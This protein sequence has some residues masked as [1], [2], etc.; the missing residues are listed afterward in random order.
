MPF[1]YGQSLNDIQNITDNDIVIVDRTGVSNNVHSPLSFGKREFFNALNEAG[2]GYSV[3]E[4]LGNISNELII[5]LGSS[6]DSL[7]NNL[8]REN[9]DILKASAESVFYKRVN[10]NN[11]TALVIG[12]SDAIGMMYALNEMS[13]QIKDKGLTALMNQESTF[14]SPE[15][16]V[17]GLDRFIK[18]ENDDDWFFSEDFWQYYVQQLAK[19]RFNRLTLITGYNDGKNEDF[20]IPV[21]PYFFQVPG[22]ENITLKKNLKNTPEAYTNQLK[23]IGEISHNYG[24]EFVFGI[25]G[26]GRSESLIDGLPKD[27]KAYTQYCSK[28]MQEL[29]R[30]VP[31]IDGIQL[32]V[33]YESG[34][35]GFGNT[36]DEFWKEII[37]AVAKANDDRNGNLF[38]DIRAKGLTPKIRKWATETEIDFSVTSK[39]TWEGVGLPYHPLQMRN[40][41]LDL[42]NNF[43]KRQRYGYA[44]FLNESRN[45]DFIYR[46]WGVGTKRMFTW[47]DPDY[48]KRFSNSTSFGDAKGFQVTPPMARKT[49]TW[50]LLS[51][52]SLV[53]YTWEDQRYWAWYL[54]FGRLGYSTATNPEVWE[55]SFK[56]HYGN[57]YPFVLDAYSAAG[58]VLPLITSSHLTNH[59]A[60]YNWAEIESGGALFTA[61]NANWLHKQKERTYQ[62]S[63]PGDPGMFYIIQDYVKDI[64]A[65]NVQ[66]KITPVQLADYYKKLADDILEHLSK[67]KPEE[68]P[69]EFQK[70]FQTN[71][72]DL[73][74]TSALSMYHA[75]KIIASMNYV[76][77][78]ETKDAA[79]LPLTIQ[80]LEK[81]KSNWE[82]IL[83]LTNKIYHTSPLF[84]HDNGTWKDRL[85]EIEKDIDSINKIAEKSKQILVND[86]RYEYGKTDIIFNNGFDAI[87][88]DVIKV[89]DTL[90]VIFKSN[91]FNKET[92]IPRVHYRMA[93]MT[94]GEFKKQK[95]IW[96]GSAYVAQIPT[97]DFNPDFDLLVYFTSITNQEEVVIYPGIFNKNHNMPYYTLEIEE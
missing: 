15:N 91:K 85:V 76:F 83:D 1:V 4:K 36:A 95:M 52:E 73:K 10:V 88:P 56:Q 64:I 45:F 32:R 19:N 61:H 54:L 75:E 63:E 27:D 26:H 9:T 86:Q 66:P 70:E 89:K 79:Y 42:I 12:G 31:E 78:E 59:P 41:E 21:Y 49:N 40:A 44:D 25:W 30:K 35:G 71:S 50:N 23:R 80:H 38:L 29:L 58:K 3:R 20:M 96:N 69:K 46:L 43:D 6:K 17:R 24:L 18:D 60:N 39:Y 51:D 67:V 90:Q 62:S 84:L 53:Y 7:V 37:Y 94:L 82:T 33:N 57:A 55:R 47:A 22:F 87:V 81:A 8:L 74:I 16:K 11:S 5:V 92:Q 2:L 97:E 65:E 28:G 68:I 14:E 93:D 72:A 77:Y 48:A 13:E 34:V